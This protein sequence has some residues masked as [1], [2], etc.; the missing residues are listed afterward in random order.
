MVDAEFYLKGPNYGGPFAGRSFQV[1]STARLIS[2]SAPTAD[3]TINAL[4]SHVWEVKGRSDGDGVCEEGEDCLFTLDR[5]ALIPTDKPGL[6]KLRSILAI[7]DGKGRFQGACG[8]VDGTTGEGE[9]NFA[10]NPP[11]VKWSFR[12]GWLCECK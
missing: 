5:A 11:T 1:L 4:T 2:Q 9:I 10:A 8:K 7:S 12:D 3:G 6:M